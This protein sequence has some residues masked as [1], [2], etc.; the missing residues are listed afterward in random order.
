MTPHSNQLVRR[1]DRV[2]HA[3]EEIGPGDWGWPGVFLVSVDS[4]FSVVDFRPSPVAIQ[5]QPPRPPSSPS[6]PDKRAGRKSSSFSTTAPRRGHRR[7]EAVAGWLG[8]WEEESRPVGVA[9]VKGDARGTGLSF[10]IEDRADWS[11]GHVKT[12]WS[13]TRGLAGLCLAARC[14]AGRRGSRGGGRGIWRGC[15]LGGLRG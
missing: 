10:P 3:R 7:L 6:K 13:R 5:R 9:R 11:L 1:I 12:A 15:C 2:Q 8:D 14:L 4:V